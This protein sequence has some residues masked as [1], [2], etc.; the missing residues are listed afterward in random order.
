MVGDEVRFTVGVPVHSKGVRLVEVEVRA[1]CRPVK[2]FHTKLGKTFLYIPDFVN[3]GNVMLKQE[4]DK[5]KLLGAHYCL[6]Y[7]CML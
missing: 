6:K 5:H 2:F 1:Q 4:R 7:H 3:G